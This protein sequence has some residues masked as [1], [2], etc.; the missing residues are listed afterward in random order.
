MAVRIRSIILLATMLM[1]ASYVSAQTMADVVKSINKVKSDTMYIYAEVT[2]K[3][4]QE[5]YNGAKAILEVKVGD[6]VRKQRPNESN[7]WAIIKAK[8]HL[9]QLETKRG[10]YYRAF[11]YVRKTDIMP[12]SDKNEVAVL[13]ISTPNKGYETKPTVVENA[14]V[15]QLSTEE[16][17]MTKVKSFYD[18]EPFI[19][20]LKSQGRL[21]AYGKYATMPTTGLV[22]IFVYDK[23]GN[24][25]A[26]LRKTNEGQVNLNTLKTDNVSNYKSCGAIWL[27]LK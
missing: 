10:D 11:V 26:L 25:A 19:K 8:D 20:N 17:E 27:Q 15:I 6:W 23:Q 5:A 22:H 21:A 1:A 24:I 9:I 2:M 13:E 18:I 12:V 16:K 7:E 4:L 14:P 3:D